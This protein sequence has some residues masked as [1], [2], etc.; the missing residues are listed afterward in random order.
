MRIP[1]F[2][3]CHDANKN[4]KSEYTLSELTWREQQLFVGHAKQWRLWCVQQAEPVEK[5]NPPHTLLLTEWMAFTTIQTVGLI[6]L[7]HPVSTTNYQTVSLSTKLSNYKQRSERYRPLTLILITHGGT[8]E[9]LKL[10]SRAGFSAF[11]SLSTI[12]DGTFLQNVSHKLFIPIF[13]TE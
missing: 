7:L 1:D 13:S 9:I 2:L 12:M 6:K 10:Y 8:R 5:A 4:S 11:I 3:L